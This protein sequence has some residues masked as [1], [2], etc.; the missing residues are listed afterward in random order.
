MV[1]PLLGGAAKLSGSIDEGDP[2]V[3][4]RSSPRDGPLLKVHRKAL[5]VVNPNALRQLRQ[6]RLQSLKKIVHLK[7][8]PWTSEKLQKRRIP[9]ECLNLW[10]TFNNWYSSCVA[11]FMMCNS[12]WSAWTAASLWQWTWTTNEMPPQLSRQLEQRCS[13]SFLRDK[14]DIQHNGHQVQHFSH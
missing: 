13:F 8:L 10:P 11:R 2:W 1:T 7:W 3:M 14:I 9:Y 5:T 4:P 12:S 6:L